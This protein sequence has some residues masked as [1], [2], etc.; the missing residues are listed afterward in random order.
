MKKLTKKTLIIVGVIIVALLIIMAALLALRGQGRNLNS[1]KAK[2]TTE[3]FVNDFL[4]PSGSK[5]S[6]T[7]ISKEY[8]LYKLLIDIGSGTPVESY[9]TKDG[10]LFFPQAFDVEKMYEEDAST[11]QVSS[12]PIDIPKSDKP[13]VELFVMSYCPYGTQI[14]KGILPVLD[15]LGDKIDFEL[16]FVDYAMHGQKE[17]D[18]NLVQYCVQKEEPNKLSDYLSCFLKAGEGTSDSCL[19]TVG[20]NSKKIASCVTD[21]DTEF[22]VTD[23][24]EN[25]VDWRGS[26]PG[27]AV[28]G[29]DN[30]RYSVAGSPTLIIN[31][32]EVSSD[33]SPAGLLATICSAFN[34]TPDVCN[35]QLSSASPSAGFGEGTATNATAAA[36]Q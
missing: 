5:A 13:S 19:T 11:S 24:Y 12:T 31:G 18:E 3:A 33:R 20:I 21:T 28:N 25:K 35:T 34:N 32:Q 1:E 17:L 36:C 7:E 30:T 10:K 26:Y 2:E 16:K 27:F 9:L 14:E 23:N 6:I 4:M 8:G 22:S 29:D 15:A